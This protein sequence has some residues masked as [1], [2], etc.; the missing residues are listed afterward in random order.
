MEVRS[1]VENEII[2]IEL[3]E[4]GVVLDGTVLM[5]SHKESIIAPNLLSK[6]SN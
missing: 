6:L 1:F 5:R 3:E 4:V 2:F